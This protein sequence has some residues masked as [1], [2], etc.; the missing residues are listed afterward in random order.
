MTIQLRILSTLATTEE[1]ISPPPML[2]MVLET[3]FKQ[4]DGPRVTQLSKQSNPNITTRM[5]RIADFSS[6]A[7][8]SSG[9]P[10]KSDYGAAKSLVLSL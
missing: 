4:T 1:V 9:N 6:I 8:P 2:A 5:L 10:K 3:V 7:A